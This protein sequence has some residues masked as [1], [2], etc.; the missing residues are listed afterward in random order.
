MGVGWAAGLGGLALL[1]GSLSLA[2]GVGRGLAAFPA[3]SRAAAMFPFIP[4]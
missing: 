1:Q 4:I 3:L 2:E